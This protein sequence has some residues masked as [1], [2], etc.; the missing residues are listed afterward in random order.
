MKCSLTL[1]PI[2]SRRRSRRRASS[3]ARCSRSSTSAAALATRTGPTRAVSGTCC[4][5][6]NLVE[7]GFIQL[8]SAQT[9]RLILMLQYGDNIAAHSPQLVSEGELG[10]L[11]QFID[12]IDGLRDGCGPMDYSPDD[13]QRALLDDISGYALADREFIRYLANPDYGGCGGADGHLLFDLM[14]GTSS[15][16]VVGLPRCE[17]GTLDYC[18]IDLRDYGWN[19]PID[20]DGDGQPD[21]DDGWEAALDA[22]GPYAVQL[23]GTEAV[24][25]AAQTQTLVPVLPLPAFVHAVASPRLYYA[26]T[27]A[28]RALQNLVATREERAD[29]PSPGVVRAGRF[30]LSPRPDRA[31]TR[32]AASGAEAGPTWLLEELSNG[33]LQ[34]EPVFRQFLG[35]EVI[36]ALPNGMRAFAVAAT[37][38]VAIAALPGCLIGDACSTIRARSPV[39]CLACHQEGLLEVSDQVGPAADSLLPTYDLETI[40]AFT[41]QYVPADALSALIAEDN[42]RE[43]SAREGAGSTVGRPNRIPRAFFAFERALALAD[44]AEELGVD[45]AALRETLVARSTEPSIAQLQPLLEEGGR[46]EREAFSL[47]YETLLCI[48]EEQT[49][50]PVT[51]SE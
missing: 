24:E 44:A 17:P 49:N 43:M 20:L 34:S 38:A 22:V 33:L 12:S 15:A 50:R 23:T 8:L 39:T 7:R 21:F 51:C 4:D 36:F 31:I 13:F 18:A 10:T 19:R 16:E 6:S 29:D 27:D 5:L 42:R 3:S 32:Y 47:A 48:H 37:D 28:D 30:M 2:R 14:N 9:S 46:V 35:G 25:V 26:L 41:A 11:I 45:S 40:S 1:C